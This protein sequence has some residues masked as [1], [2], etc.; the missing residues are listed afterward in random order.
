[1]AQILS[2]VPVG[3]VVKLKEGGSLVNFI[4]VHQGLPSEIYDAS[5]NGTWVLRQDILENI[6]WADHKEG[7]FT[8]YSGSYLPSRVDSIVSTLDA[9]VQKLIRS[10]KVPLYNG[11]YLSTGGNGLSCRGI[12]LSQTE[13]GILE[14]GGTVDGAKLDYFNSYTA[15]SDNH[16]RIA[17]LNGEPAPYW[18]RTVTSERTYIRTITED[19]KLGGSFYFESY[20]LRYAMVLEP[21]Y[22]VS[23][24]GTV[25][26]ITQPTSISVQ[27]VIVQGRSIALSWSPVDGAEGYLVQ[28]KSDNGEW[29][30]VYRGAELSCSDIAGTWSSVQYRVQALYEGLGGAWKESATVTV[31]SDSIL[32]ISGQDGGLGTLTNDVT[33][34]AYSNTGHTISLS[35]SV[36]ELLWKTENVS[37]GQVRT[38]PVVDLPTGSGTIVITAQVQ[39]DLGP[40]SAS[41]TW[42][43]Q[44]TAAV[45]PTAG[46]VVQLTQKGK[47]KWPV[48]LAEAVRTPDYMG[49]NLSKTLE[50]LDSVLEDVRPNLLINPCFVGGGTGWGVFPINQRGKTSYGASYGFD[51]WG[52]NGGTVTLG[53]TGVTW[54]GDYVLSQRM[55]GLNLAD[56][57]TRTV[58]YVDENQHGFSGILTNAYTQ[59][60]DYQFT[61][62]TGISFYMRSPKSSPAMAW[63]KLEEGENQTLF[64]ENGDG[65]VTILPQGLDYGQELMKC[66]QYLQ[67]YSSADARPAKAVD[68]RPVMRIDP[69]QTTIQIGET[70]YYVNSAE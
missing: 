30:Q 15:D 53:P 28:R 8:D 25:L 56:G 38:I 57:K 7:N 37:S 62:A 12:I 36:N 41:R 35:L 42:S 3:T 21:Q 23:D 6:Q 20:G 29:V 55:Y 17:N 34:S 22:S 45:V 61:Y 40:T 11:Y 64:A 9:G 47:N 4:V 31:H 70:T 32:T 52:M 27:S 48:T 5:C 43:Y 2:A 16:C 46:L 14:N 10:V 39:T 33:Y 50:M 18:T 66:Q 60:G 51:R 67:L 19:G 44:K 54:S 13:Y 24:D 68:C 63:V 69:T 1:M 65:T 26:A 58:S 49:G 59:I